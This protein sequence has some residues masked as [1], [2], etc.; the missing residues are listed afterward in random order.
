MMRSWLTIGLAAL[1]L[2][3]LVG[4]GS[5]AVEET[6]PAAPVMEPVLATAVPD[7]SP[8]METEPPTAVPPAAPETEPAVTPAAVEETAVEPTPLPTEAP[9]VEQA[10]GRPQLVEFYADW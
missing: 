4:C 6:A 10:V 8:P 1:L 7:T 2:V 3:L 9:V 5:G